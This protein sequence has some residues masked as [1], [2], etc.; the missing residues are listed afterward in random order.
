MRLGR[1]SNSPSMEPRVGTAHGMLLLGPG[2]LV[3]QGAKD[4]FGVS[5]R[6]SILVGWKKPHRRV[7]LRSLGFELRVVSSLSD[8]LHQ[9]LTNI[10]GQAFGCSQTSQRRQ[11]YIES[12]L[13]ERR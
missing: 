1:P 11:F 7:D 12:L 8:G 4:S 5:H 9:R 13:L 6:L 2:N 10:G 3:P